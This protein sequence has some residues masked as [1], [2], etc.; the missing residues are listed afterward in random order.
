MKNLDRAYHR[1]RIEELLSSFPV[2]ALIGPRQVGKTTLARQI[3]E[4]HEPCHL[5]DLEDP[6]D[7]ARLSEPGL[8][9]RPLEG[10]IIIDEIQFMPELFELL[11]VLADRADKPAQFLILGSA[12]PELVR[13]SSESLAGRVAYHR[14]EGLHLGEV[15]DDPS[16]L[17]LRGGFPRS[18]LAASDEESAEWR[19]QFIATFLQRDIPALGI[20]IPSSRLRRF[21][22]M[23]AH[24]HGQTWNAS[25]FAR[26][27][28]VSDHTVRNYLDLLTDTYVVRQLQPWHANV[29]KRQV[30]SPKVYIEDSGLVHTLLGL[31]TRA[32]VES[33]PK[34]GAS[35]EGFAMQ[36][37]AAR[38]GARPDE[39]FF[40]AT[41]A[42]A[43][44]D[45]LVVRGNQRRGFEFKRTDS[46]KTTKS[47][48]SAL[49]D[50]ELGQ[51]YVIHG[52]R[53]SFPL[54]ERI[55]AVPLSALGEIEPL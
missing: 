10:L 27:F 53:H 11:R 32:D 38:L 54:A 5:F 42:G 23:L 41:H 28:G 31:E 35:W 22:T 4:N 40:W 49:S 34:L 48:H 47:M 19:R 14:L 13:D 21:W 43:E 1:D 25:E 37:V 45:L 3:A 18:Y 30:K 52:G 39:C 17:W 44:L 26:S 8:T 51:L 6:Q 7:R 12:S 29:A 20:D 24:Y 33:H 46:P 55:M 9:L 16:K 36:E 50:L 2:V 15:S